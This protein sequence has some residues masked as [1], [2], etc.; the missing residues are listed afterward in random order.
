MKKT[1]KNIYLSLKYFSLIWGNINIDS[2]AKIRLSVIRGNVRIGPKASIYQS[3]IYGNINIGEATSLTGPG[4]FIHSIKKTVNLKSYISIAP[5]VKIITS[6]HSLDASTTSFRAGGMQT[7]KNI[8]IGHHSWLAAG[9][10]ITEGTVI[11]DYSVIASGGV[12]VGKFY[13]GRCIWGGVPLKR[14]GDY[15]PDG[16]QT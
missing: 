9:A 11:G 14:I 12:A 1:I 5:G 3:N 7:E 15:D 8:E 13:K 16:Q 6:G 4:L 2:S 10:I